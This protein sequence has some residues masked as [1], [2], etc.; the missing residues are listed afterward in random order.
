VARRYPIRRIKIHRC[1]SVAEVAKL[2]DV[3]KHTV[4]RWI[5][6]GLPLIEKKRPYLIHGADLRV[7]LTARQPRRQLCRPGEIFCIRC[8]APK[9]PAGDMVDYR[10]RTPAT[11]I[12]QGICPTCNLLIHRAARFTALASVCADLNVTHQNPQQ[13]L[14][15]SPGPFRNVAFAKEPH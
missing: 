7:F 3:H 15:D 6:T 5:A 1:Y 10:P 14:V 13:R 4:S 11:G 9:R 2:L 8:R 12:L